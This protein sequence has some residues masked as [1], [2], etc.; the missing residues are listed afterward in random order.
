M[1][2]WNKKILPSI[3]N[4][5]SILNSS[6]NSTD[7]EASS[8]TNTS[9]QE[10]RPPKTIVCLSKTPLSSFS[11]RFVND[12]IRSISC[13]TS[14]FTVDTGT[15][16]GRLF[17]NDKAV[18]TYKIHHQR[19]RRTQTR[20]RKIKSYSKPTQTPNY[21]L[22]NIRES[23]LK[24]FPNA[25]ILSLPQDQFS[26]L[27]QGS[28]NLSFSESSILQGLKIQSASG[29]TGYNVLRTIIPNTFPS[30]RTIRRA[31]SSFYICPGVINSVIELFSNKLLKYPQYNQKI[32]LSFDEFSISPKVEYS[33]QHQMIV[34]L[35]TLDPGYAN[36]QVQNCLIIVAQCLTLP[37]RIPVSVDFTASSTKP[38]NL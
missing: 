4:L 23:I 3:N 22:S 16:P 19:T 15:N 14:A 8:S 38:G 12:A 37:I 1:E 2:L 27:I 26:R 24:S 33:S 21:S 25:P 32:V 28:S 35:T 7:I 6:K 31:T 34:G 10:N 29:T 20:T 5:E 36:S 18:Q 13:Q 11:K 17:E 30:P 9:D